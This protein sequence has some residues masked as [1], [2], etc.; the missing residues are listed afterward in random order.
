MTQELGIKKWIS[1]V[2]LMLSVCILYHFMH[3]ICIWGADGE[4]SS[5]SK[6]WLLQIR[7]DNFSLHGSGWWKIPTIKSKA[8]D[9]KVVGLN[10]GCGVGGAIPDFLSSKSRAVLLNW[11]PRSALELYQQEGRINC[12]LQTCKVHKGH[13]NSNG[14]WRGGGSPTKTLSSNRHMVMGQ[15]WGP[16]SHVGVASRCL[17]SL[18]TNPSWAGE[19]THYNISINAFV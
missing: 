3:Q 2:I 17:H 16:L 8:S 7:R 18:L 5:W 4:V 6:G 1:F 13:I 11:V 19:T 9:L 10:P 15:S 14:E 12:Y